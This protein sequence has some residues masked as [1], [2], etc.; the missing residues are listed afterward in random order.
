MQKMEGRG[1]L[2]IIKDTR[3]ERFLLR[4][5]FVISHWQTFG[6]HLYISRFVL[7]SGHSSSITNGNV[8]KLRMT[9]LKGEGQHYWTSAEWK[10][11]LKL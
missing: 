6:L 9:S 8:L 10:N 4:K 7:T 2:E 5:S 3:S 11:S 1:T